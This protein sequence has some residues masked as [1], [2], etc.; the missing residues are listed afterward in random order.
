MAHPRTTDLEIPE[1][2]CPF[3]SRISPHADALEA[4]NLAWL[5]L[6][7]L[8]PRG[9]ARA[10]FGRLAARAY[11][12]ACLDT[13]GIAAAW[14]TWLFL[15]DDQCDEGGISCDPRAMRI[16]A[17]HQIDVLAG[18]RPHHRDDPLTSAL[19]DLR[20]RMLARGGGRWMARFLGNVQDYF[21]ASIWESDNRARGRVPDLSTYVRL[22]DLTGAV[23]TCFDIF[24]LIEGALAIEARHDARLARLMRLA[25]RAIC[26]SN[27]LFSIRKEL[28]HGDFHNLAIVL[29][30]EE[31]IPLRDAIDRAVEMHDDAVRSFEHHEHRLLET[32][33][34]PQIHQFVDA[35]KGW[36]RANLDWSIETGRY[37]RIEPAIDAQRILA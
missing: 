20:D 6:L 17:D 16:L 30:H 22:R 11:P 5:E 8:V 34:S 4:A 23:R 32:T 28:A 1:L 31:A 7:Q 12:D 37:A 26:W 27:D 24:E 18:R 29:Q 3:V 13:L 2:Y 15:R 35:L 25:N 36:V 10:R 14:A 9:G 21:D 19:A 33:G